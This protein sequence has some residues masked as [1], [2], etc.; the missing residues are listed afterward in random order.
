M[1]FRGILKKLQSWWRKITTSKTFAKLNVLKSFLVKTALSVHKKI[2][3]IPIYKKLSARISRLPKKY[4]VTWLI[5]C[6]VIIFSIGNFIINAQLNKNL[7]GETG[8]PIPQLVKEAPNFTTVLPQGKTIDKL[9]GWTRI[10]PPS[11]SPV[12]TFTDK[13]DNVRI[14]ISEQPLPDSFKIDP[15]KQ[16]EQFAQSED[17]TEKIS[18]D[19]VTVYIGTSSKGPQSVFLIKNNLLVLIKSDAII[20]QNQWIKYINSLQ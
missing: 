18:V 19:D 6:T 4:K 8:V 5:I 1:A 20:S 12:Y 13:L 17:A 10:S 16:L 2:Q 9:G 15:A 3:K 11:T 7:V 14:N